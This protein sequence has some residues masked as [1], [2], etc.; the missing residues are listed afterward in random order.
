MIHFAVSA[1][2]MIDFGLPTCDSWLKKF[3]NVIRYLI[4]YFEEKNT[5]NNS[6]RDFRRAT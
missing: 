6:G 1:I 4:N 2:Y 5:F 3:L